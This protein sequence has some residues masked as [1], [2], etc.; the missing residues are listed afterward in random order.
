MR[1]ACAAAAGLVWGCCGVCEQGELAR[2]VC[3]EHCR[4]SASKCWLTIVGW[5][6]ELEDV[7]LVRV[8]R[9]I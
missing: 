1:A 2:R 4:P 8:M 9:V 6:S 5:L 3:F 7:T